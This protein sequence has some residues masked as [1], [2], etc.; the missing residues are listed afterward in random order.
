VK[1]ATYQGV[2]DVKVM[3]VPKPS[4]GGD[5]QALIRVTLGAICGSDLHAYHGRIPMSAGELLALDDRTVRVALWPNGRTGANLRRGERVVICFVAPNL[6]I[7]PHWWYQ[8]QECNGKKH[9]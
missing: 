2:G 1:A 6:G 3:D 7:R 8:T 4:L 9:T 5:D